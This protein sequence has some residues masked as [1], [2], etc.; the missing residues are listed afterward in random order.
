M[1]I[2]RTVR[3]VAGS[4]IGAPHGDRVR[5]VGVIRVVTLSADLPRLYREHGVK[6]GAVR[7]MTGST[8]IDHRSVRYRDFA[9]RG[10]RETI[11]ADQ[12]QPSSG[13][14]QHH[15]HFTFA[16]FKYVATQAVVDRGRVWNPNRDD[17]VVAC[18]TGC[19]FRVH[20][21][22]VVGRR[23]CS[24]DC[25]GDQHNRQAENHAEGGSVL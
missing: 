21:C 4:A 13:L 2:L 3:L 17:L 11:V 22:R 8:V 5:G 24:R 19:L 25:S 9:A 7:T 10:R 12:T 18:F 1:G 23:A 16:G 6:I 15:T 14:H 20:E